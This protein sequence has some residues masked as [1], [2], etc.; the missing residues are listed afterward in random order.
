MKIKSPMET[1]RYLSFEVNRIDNERVQI[2]KKVFQ[3]IYPGIQSAVHQS[4]L[5]AFDFA[6]QAWNDLQKFGRET[7]IEIPRRYRNGFMFFDH[8]DTRELYN[9]LKP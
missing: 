9:R 2:A 5:D 7:G 6:D 4:W 3:E 1:I 8:D